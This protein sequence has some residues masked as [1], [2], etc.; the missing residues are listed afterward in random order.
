MEKVNRRKPVGIN[1]DNWF[2]YSESGKSIEL[3]HRCR[4][5]LGVYVQTDHIKIPLKKIKLLN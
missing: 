3:I 1:K 4:N 5:R 2:Y